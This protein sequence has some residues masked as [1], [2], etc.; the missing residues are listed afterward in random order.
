MLCEQLTSTIDLLLPVIALVAL[1]MI[2]DPFSEITQTHFMTSSSTFESFYIYC[3]SLLYALM[4]G[5]QVPLVRSNDLRRKGTTLAS[6]S[7][8]SGRIGVSASVSQFG[9]GTGT[10][11]IN[12]GTLCFAIYFLIQANMIRCCVL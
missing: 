10:Q 6:H 2:I 4:F 9:S 5:L 8:S 11:S 7:F 12:Q 1:L 3:K